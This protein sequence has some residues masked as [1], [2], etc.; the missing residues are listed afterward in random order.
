[1]QLL[2]LTLLFTMF[3][4]VF[5]YRYSLEDEIIGEKFFHTFSHE[6]IDDPTHG[7][8]EYVDESTARS[9]NLSYASDDHF[10]IRG[11]HTTRL[12]AQQ[13]K[14]RKSVRIQS[15]KAY[16]NTGTVMVVDIRHMPTACGTWPALWTCGENW[17]HGGEIDLI[18]GVNNM[19]PNLVS[20]HTA[21]GCQQPAAR[22]QKGTPS[23]NDCNAYV[24]YNQGCGV[25]I[26]DDASFGPSFNAIGG[27]W[28][29]LERTT[30]EIK[31]WFWA[32]NDPSVPA[33]VS[34]RHHHSRGLLQ[35][36]IGGGDLL[37]GKPHHPDT[38]QVDT[39]QWG[40]PDVRFVKDQ[41]DIPGHFKQEKIIINLT[42][43]GDW[44][45][46]YFNYL[47]SGCPSS[48]VDF[49][50]S[51]PEAFVDA[52]WDLRSIRV[53]NQPSQNENQQ[54]DLFPRGHEH[55]AGH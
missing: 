4:A 52:Y 47:R 50:N 9:L 39:S 45:G 14:G 40:T 6:A 27:G 7:R 36:P 10:I 42:F 17:P 8:V 1:M 41:C 3:P 24:N 49:V 19:S 33:D 32:R 18:E 54:P 15:K 48:C 44:A 20:L 11:D 13:P 31:A 46:E 26:S 23:S 16:S 35:A 28:Y 37:N 51:N 22:V 30:D 2:I 12:S 55:E 29:A 43:C 21:P 25:H 53:Y 5:A 34:V 38:L